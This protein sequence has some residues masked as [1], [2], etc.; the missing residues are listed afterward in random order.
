VESDGSDRSRVFTMMLWWRLRIDVPPSDALK[1]SESWIPTDREVVDATLS[2]DDDGDRV[3]M[4]S[5]SLA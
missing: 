4:V 3:G 5:L 1:I 2:R